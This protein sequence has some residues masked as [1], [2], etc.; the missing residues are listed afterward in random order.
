MTFDISKINSVERCAHAA[1]MDV[2]DIDGLPIVASEEIDEDEKIIQHNVAFLVLGAQAD[3][4]A[5]HAN[6]AFNQRM[7]EEML[8]RKTGKE[9]KQKTL[10]EI[11]ESNIE[12]ALIRVVGWKNVQQEFSKDLLKA[13][14]KK[15]PH[16]IT[17]II[18]FSNDLRNFTKAS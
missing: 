3:V 18:E 15:N 14:I 2:L 4:V 17:Q 7:Q 5:K 9:V 11:H 16:W 12:S 1:E 6:K 10:E 13:A 8:A